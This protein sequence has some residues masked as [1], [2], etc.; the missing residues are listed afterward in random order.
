MKRLDKKVKRGG[1]IIV[2]KYF[3]YNY[4]T[5]KQVKRMKNIAIYSQS[6]DGKIIA[7]E[8]VRIRKHNGFTVRDIEVEPAETYPPNSTWGKDGFSYTTLNEAE[9]KMKSLLK[10]KPSQKV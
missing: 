3:I 9:I 8:T 1:Y 7:Y 5:F 4:F 2:S 6:A 10:E